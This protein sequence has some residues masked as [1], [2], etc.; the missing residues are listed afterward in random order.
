[1][2]SAL[3]RRRREQLWHRAFGRQ[4]AVP[5]RPAPA[6]AAEVALRLGASEP[7]ARML[8]TGLRY[9]SQALAGQGRMLPTVF[10]A[11]VGSQN[12][13]LWVAPAD[14]D[15]PAPWVA[16]FEGPIIVAGDPA[17]ALARAFTSSTWPTVSH[18]V[19]AS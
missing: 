9:L 1:M 5:V 17:R 15:A 3:G 4:L 8:D 14:R 19:G 13:D 7:S 18:E 2:L 16:S 11:H 12:L 6:A 10:A